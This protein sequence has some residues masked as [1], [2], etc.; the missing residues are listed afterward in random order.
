MSSNVH[1]LMT[2][3]DMQEQLFECAFFTY[4]KSNSQRGLI[5]AHRAKSL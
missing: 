4:D 5:K 1:I 3:Y 2:L